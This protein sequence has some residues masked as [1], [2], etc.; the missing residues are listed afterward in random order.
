[1]EVDT[2]DAWKLSAGAVVGPRSCSGRQGFEE[3]GCWVCEMS[4]GGARGGDVGHCEAD[5]RVSRGYVVD[6]VAR[7]DAGVCFCMRRVGWCKDR[8]SECKGVF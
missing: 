7:L 4:E 5:S 1:M 2:A 8:V 3:G 6:E